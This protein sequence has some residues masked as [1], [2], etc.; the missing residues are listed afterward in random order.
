MSFIFLRA[1]FTLSWASLQPDVKLIPSHLFPTMCLF[2]VNKK[3][4]GLEWPKL[5][6]SYQWPAGKKKVITHHPD[7]KQ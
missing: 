7:H 2:Q 5:N 1:E 6:M 3:Y 4:D